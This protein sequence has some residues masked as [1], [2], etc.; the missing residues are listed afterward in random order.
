VKLRNREKFDIDGDAR[1]SRRARARTPLAFVSLLV[2]LFAL[3]IS[4]LSLSPL[5][6]PR[7]SAS[8]DARLST[9][10]REGRLTVFDDVWQTVG[11]RYYD[12]SMRGVDW[13]AERARLRPLA[14][15]AGTQAEFYTILR[16]LLGALGDA[17]TRVFT[18]EE[19]SE[20]HR[21]VYVSV[22]LAARELDGEVIVTRVER[23]SEAERAGVRAGDAVLTIDGVPARDAL[24][25]RADESAAGPKRAGTAAAARLFDGPRD[26]EV[27]LTLS[28]RNGRERERTVRLRRTLQT[29][30]PWLAFRR[31]ED[32]TIVSFN[33]FT[34][35][36]AVRLMRELRARAAAGEVGE[37]IVVDLRDNGGGDAEAMIDIASAFLPAGTAL[38]QFRGRTGE[39]AV[40]P[41]TRRAMLLAADEVSSYDG[42]VVV[43][44]GP[45]TASAAEIFAAALQER[46]RARVVGEPTCG[47]VLAIRRRHTLPDGGLLDIS[48]MDYHTARERRLEGAGVAPDEAV[49]L[50]RRDLSEG[51][52]AA[53]LRALS[54]LKSAPRAARAA[55]A[56]ASSRQDAA[57]ALRRH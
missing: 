24:S 38:G 25:R 13:E 51:R 10:T 9:G 6:L 11:D 33:F 44:T 35:E 5:P 30:E 54:L 1:A 47:C 37:G 42:P 45:R 20:W 26:T 50:T 48:E 8:S 18:P 17:H 34:Q 57:P 19:R 41:R 36:I 14:A 7:A 16:R 52:D 53:L 32:S 29:R 49:G 12:P 23:E 21:P 39:V 40:A 31:A 4:A 22:G 27:T 2:V 28:A 55:A 3:V 46:G 15:A 43:L 56:P